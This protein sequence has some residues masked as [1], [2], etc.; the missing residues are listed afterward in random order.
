MQPSANGS[1]AERNGYRDPKTLMDLKQCWSGYF[2]R[3]NAQL[4]ALLL[5]CSAALLLCC[6]AALLLCCSAALQ[7]IHCPQQACK[8]WGD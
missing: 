8:S 2:S 4:V 5:C 7:I 1:T 6:S 3:S